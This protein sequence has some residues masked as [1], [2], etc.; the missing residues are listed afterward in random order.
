MPC[1]SDFNQTCGGSEF[2]NT[3]TSQYAHMTRLPH[4]SIMRVMTSLNSAGKREARPTSEDNQ[5]PRF[6]LFLLGDGEKKVTEEADT[7]EFSLLLQRRE[8]PH[9]ATT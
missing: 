5:P 4:N 3:I 9:K 7:R 8:F 6:E 2:G 1:H